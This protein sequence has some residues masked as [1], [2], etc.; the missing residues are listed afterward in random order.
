[1]LVTNTYTIEYDTV[2][3]AYAQLASSGGI[4]MR[5]EDLELGSAV[6][7]NAPIL[8]QAP[9]AHYGTSGDRF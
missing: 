4:E 5:D 3:N 9:N 2:R 7:E 6:P 8:R 1:M